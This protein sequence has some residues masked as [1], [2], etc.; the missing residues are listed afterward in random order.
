VVEILKSNSSQWLKSQVI[1][2][3]AWQ[4]GY[5]CFSVGK[6]QAETLVQYIARVATAVGV[7]GPKMLKPE[8]TNNRSARQCPEGVIIVGDGVHISQQIRYV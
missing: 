6:S 8:V 4:R 2:E 1:S 5:G 7:A 3:C